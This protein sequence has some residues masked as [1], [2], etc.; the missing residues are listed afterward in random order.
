MLKNK[1]KSELQTTFHFFYNIVNEGIF[2]CWLK[3]PTSETY[4]NICI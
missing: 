2:F 3:L 4:K 1:K